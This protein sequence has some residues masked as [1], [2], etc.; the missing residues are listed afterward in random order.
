MAHGGCQKKISVD[1]LPNASEAADWYDREARSSLTRVSAFGRN[2]FQ[3]AEDQEAVDR[4][5]STQCPDI[6][7]L[8]ESAVNFQ[9]AQYQNALKT[10]IDIVRSHA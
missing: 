9:H 1:L 4:Q 3:S 7:S 8:F 6:C 5:F 10:L 2:P